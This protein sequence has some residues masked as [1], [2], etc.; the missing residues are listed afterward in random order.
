[1]YTEAV[2]QRYLFYSVGAEGGVQTGS[3]TNGAVHILRLLTL[4][5]LTGDSKYQLPDLQETMSIHPSVEA[6]I[7][8]FI[9][10]STHPFIY[11]DST[12][13]LSNTFFKILEI[14]VTKQQQQ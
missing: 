1:M 10:P 9:D 11:R 4:I 7:C 3:V 2:N 6:S 5:R 14:M 8:P 12:K 13:Y